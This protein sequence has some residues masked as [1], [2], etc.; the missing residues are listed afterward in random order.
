RSAGGLATGEL[1]HAAGHDQPQPPLNT[2][3]S[4]EALQAQHRPAHRS[5][6]SAKIEADPEPKALILARIATLTFA[7][8]VSDLRATFPPDR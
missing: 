5:G 2:R 8:I 4:R 6:R 7:Q 1:H 3:Q